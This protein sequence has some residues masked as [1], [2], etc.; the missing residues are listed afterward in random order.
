MHV[1]IPSR[2]RGP[3]TSGNGG[4]TCG[5]VAG[6]IEGPAEV[7][8]RIPPPLEVP[9]AVVREVAAVR[10]LHGETLVAEGRPSDFTLELPQAPA[11]AEAKAAGRGYLGLRHHDWPSCFVCS[12]QRAEGDGLRIFCGPWKDG[13]VAGT[14]TP[15]ADLSDENG[16]VRPE[17]L[18]SAIDCPGAWSVIGREDAQ[19]AVPAPP[20][21]LLLGRLAG[22]LLRN[23]RAGDDCVV[24]GWP[25]GVDGRKYHVGTAVFTADGEPVCYSRATWIAVKPSS[26]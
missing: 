24:I 7:M 19:A 21:P 3:P 23:L 26:A 11:Y 5:L 13:V 9:L 14:W 6:F 1:T 4:Y 16:N 10:L 22:R 17:F 18:W 20:A 12:P 2:F 15:T 8:L 25:L